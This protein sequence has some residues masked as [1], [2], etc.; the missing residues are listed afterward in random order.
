MRNYASAVVPV[1]CILRFISE[2]GKHLVSGAVAVDS[3]ESASCGY[4]FGNCLHEF[5]RAVRMDPAAECRLVGHALSCR[6]D[7]HEGYFVGGIGSVDLRAAYRE[8]LEVGIAR[9]EAGRVL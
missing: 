3:R 4:E 1:S 9:E 8:V 6:L 5:R 2:V 7:R